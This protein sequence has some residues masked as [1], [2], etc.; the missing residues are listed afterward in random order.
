VQYGAQSKLE[1]SLTH[2]IE[3]LDK[4]IDEMVQ[5]GGPPNLNAAI[6]TCNAELE[7]S[8]YVIRK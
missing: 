1:S 4:K 8:R 3:E 2:R 5:L 7:L 6:S